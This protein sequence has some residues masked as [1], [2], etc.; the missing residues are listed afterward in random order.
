MVST[1]MNCTALVCIAHAAIFERSI[2]DL[3]REAKRSH[4]SIIAAPAQVEVAAAKVR[5]TRDQGCANVQFVGKYS[6]N[7]RP[8]SLGFGIPTFPA[9][10][11]EWYIG[12]QVTIPFFKGF[13]RNCPVCQAEAQVEEQRVELDKIVQAL[14][15]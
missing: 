5:E 2:G 13:T 14:F 6:E 9:T 11:H 7:N 8:A 4:P 10:G 3:L 15:I 1:P 12:V